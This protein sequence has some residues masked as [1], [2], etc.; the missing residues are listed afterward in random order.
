M[1]RLISKKIES[2]I[3]RLQR[4]CPDPLFRLNFCRSLYKSFAIWKSTFDEEQHASTAQFSK[5]MQ[6]Y[7]GKAEQYFRRVE[8]SRIPKDMVDI[9]RRQRYIVEDVRRDE[10]ESML[11]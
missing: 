5:E 7:R 11:L 8:R 9:M 4:T 10:D 6:G 3:I 1:I 2:S